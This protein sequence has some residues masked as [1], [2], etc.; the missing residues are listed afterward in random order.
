MNGFKH[1]VEET[2]L[3]RALWNDGYTRPRPEKIVQA[4]ASMMWQTQCRSAGVDLS[5]EVNIGR[6]P[7]D[8]KFSAGW[9]RRALTE[10]KLIKST[11]FF[12]GAAK[13][14]PQY[15]K[16]EQIEFG[17]Y[18]CV[19]FTDEDFGEERLGRV[20][21]TCAALADKKGIRIT[22]VFVDAQPHNKTSASKQR[23]SDDGA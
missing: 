1:A 7:V 15:L 3:W 22:P 11:G 19:G 20:Q 14:L 18:L 21:E 13:Q 6:G 12:A 17:Y 9:H 10:V 23:E 16:S 2:D 4:I 8:F 5:R